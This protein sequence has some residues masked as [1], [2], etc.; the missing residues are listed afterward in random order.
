MTDDGQR[1]LY[2]GPA[3]PPKDRELVDS[4]TPGRSDASTWGPYHSV[5]FPPR[6]TT[7][8]IRYKI[9]TTGLNI[10]KRLW[11]EREAR[12]RAYESV[13]G[14]DPAHWPTR[15]PAVVLESVE[16]TAHAGCLGCQWLDR[17]GVYMKV[18]GWHAEAT[19]NAEQHQ[20]SDG[21]LT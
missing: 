16:W 1:P 20:E 3:G 8:W 5:L 14:D 10:A 4:W 13:H 15:H 9:M 11:D 2:W 21:K 12:R 17:E 18:D 6:K 19:K 7:P